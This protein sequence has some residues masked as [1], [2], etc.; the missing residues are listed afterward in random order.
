MLHTLGHTQFLLSP[1]TYAF[2][3]LLGVL[4]LSANDGGSVREMSGKEIK[5]RG[6]SCNLWW[7]LLIET[8][9]GHMLEHH[10]A[11]GNLWI[12]GVACWGGGR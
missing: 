9:E 2:S 11:L 8:L 10:M 6:K 5:S 3:T 7:K 12:Y 4:S 1:L